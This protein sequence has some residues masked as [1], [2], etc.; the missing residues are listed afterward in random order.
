[1]HT[2]KPKSYLFVKNLKRQ[3]VIDGKLNIGRD[4]VFSD[5]D[6]SKN[7]CLIAANDQGQYFLRDTKSRTG[8]FLN[9]LRIP[10]D[11]W[12]AIPEKAI[13]RC[14]AFEMIYSNSPMVLATPKSPTPPLRPWEIREEEKKSAAPVLEEHEPNTNFLLG[15][16]SLNIIIFGLIVL[17]GGDYNGVSSTLLTKFG[18]NVPHLS[19]S[20]EWWR[21]LSY[22]FLHLNLFHL[23]GNVLA[24]YFA[25]SHISKYLSP[26]KISFIYLGSAFAAGVTSAMMFPVMTVSVGA[27]GAIMG[28][29]GAIVAGALLGRRPGLSQDRWLLITAAQFAIQNMGIGHEGVDYWCH[30]GGFFSGM[31]LTVITTRTIPEGQWEWP[32]L[33]GA[34][35]VGI[36]ATLM[37]IPVKKMTGRMQMEPYFK[38]FS[39]LSADVTQQIR[40]K[41]NSDVAVAAYIDGTFLKDITELRKLLTEAKPVDARADYFKKYLLY[42]MSKAESNMKYVS[43]YIKTGD[44]H[45]LNLAK[46]EDQSLSKSLKQFP[47]DL[48]S[49]QVYQS[50]TKEKK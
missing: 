18:A 22:S 39:Q 42:V 25:A 36:V 5:L 38:V 41:G 37:A 17:A 45:Y 30:L 48:A 20:G 23:A 31:A 10:Q 43:L 13:I 46:R 34:F 6:I 7:H 14:G 33:G 11:Q 29:Y 3:L 12:I 35:A 19:T 49:E 2:P 32:K 24:L 28:L 47:R 9:N 44:K 8:T 21:F 50:L 40:K 1:M 15:M 27:S 26:A 16:A 4:D